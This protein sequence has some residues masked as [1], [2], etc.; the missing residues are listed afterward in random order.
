MRIRFNE[1]IGTLDID[2]VMISAAVLRELVDPDRRLLFRF[3]RKDGI[4]TAVALDERSVIWIDPVD[5]VPTDQ[6]IEFGALDQKG[7]EEGK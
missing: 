3:L 7:N 6:A 5:Q 2:G 1:E 4:I